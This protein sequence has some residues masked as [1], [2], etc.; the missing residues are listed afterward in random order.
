MYN[1]VKK[2][3]KTESVKEKVSGVHNVC[4]AEN[5]ARVSNTV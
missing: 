5:I 4:S 2:I 1:V 3:K